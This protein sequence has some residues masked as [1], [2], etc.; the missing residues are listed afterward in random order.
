MRNITISLQ[1]SYAIRISS[2]SLIDSVCQE[3]KSKHPY[4]REYSHVFGDLKQIWTVF[5]F[6]L[7]GHFVLKNQKISGEHIV[8]EKEKIN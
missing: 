2:W 4:N 8:N 6:Y 1:N 5:V 7:S 3:N